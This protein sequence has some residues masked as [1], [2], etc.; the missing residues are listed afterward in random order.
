MAVI[1][2][3]IYLLS[4]ILKAVFIFYG[5][6]LPLD[7]TLFSGFLLL[8]YI[9][10]DFFINGVKLK[11]QTNNI[12]ALLILLFFFAWTVISLFYGASTGYGYRKI[13]LFLTNI[14]AFLF[15]LLIKRFDLLKFIK[16]FSVSIIFSFAWFYYVY[17]VLIGKLKNTEIF[18]QLMGLSLTLAVY[19]GLLLLVLI[20]SRNRIFIN[21]FVNIVMIIL[22]AGF[23]ALSGAR[24]PIFFVI[25]SLS[26]FCLLRLHKI[27]ISKKVKINKILKIILILP[28]LILPFIFGIFK[29]YDK[30]LT[31]LNRSL[32]RI[33]LI[34]NGVGNDGDMGNSVNVRIDQ[35]EFAVKSVFENLQN[36]LVG[37][38]FG[39]FGI[40]YSGEDGRL[41]P[42][43]IM[44]E[45]WFELGFIGFFIFSAFLISVFFSDIKQER[46]I[47]G[48]VMLYI[49]L[50]MMKSSSIVD[51]RVFFAF[52]A[53]FIIKENLKK[54]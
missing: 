31:L 15:P 49:F 41:Y 7:I 2:Y 8:F 54:I 3:L 51:I 37:Y 30:I 6:R 34:I 12:S 16:Y 13:F 50:N 39:S 46:I 35:M 43:N 33:L 45:I 20:T 25:I 22:L 47:S 48:S 1:L 29:Y 4:G 14:I 53:L 24:G 44:L 26:L 21:V 18:Y 5:F 27:K 28:V 17:F 36:F 23:L 10:Y 32:Y 11:I 52:F 42:H 9:G 19:G 40:M 38:G